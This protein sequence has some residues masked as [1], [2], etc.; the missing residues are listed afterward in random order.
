MMTRLYLARKAAQQWIIAAAAFFISP[1]TGVCI[2]IYAPSLP[3]IAH[4]FSS[5]VTWA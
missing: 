2:N 5:N 4:Y 1:I 3:E